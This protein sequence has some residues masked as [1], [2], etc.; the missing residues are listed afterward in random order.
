M[1]Q[2]P[3]EAYRITNAASIDF[4]TSKAS[5]S[6]SESCLNNNIRLLGEYCSEKLRATAVEEWANKSYHPLYSLGTPHTDLPSATIEEFRRIF[7]TV[8]NQRTF[9]RPLK[10]VR[11]QPFRFYSQTNPQQPASN[12]STDGTAKTLIEQTDQSKQH[13]QE[14]SNG[15]NEQKSSNNTHDS[16]STTVAT[17]APPKPKWR[18]YLAWVTLA[19]GVT[20]I[21]SHFYLKAITRKAEDKHAKSIKLDQ[22]LND[23][24]LEELRVYNDFTCGDTLHVQDRLKKEDQESLP[25]EKL[26]TFADFN[27]IVEQVCGKRFKLNYLMVR[28]LEFHER[29]YER[30]EMNSESWLLFMTML[31]RGTA[32]DRLGTSFCVLDRTGLGEISIIELDKLITYAVYM[33]WCY[34]PRMYRQTQKYPPAFTSWPLDELIQD[35]EIK[36]INWKPEPP[37][38]PPKTMMQKFADLLGYQPPE[39]KVEDKK[40]EIEKAEGEAVEND[41]DFSKET[42]E[43]L[44]EEEAEEMALKE[45]QLSF[46]KFSAT[47]CR[48]FP[49]HSTVLRD[50]RNSQVVK[51]ESC[52]GGSP[53]KFQSSSGELKGGS[54][55]LSRQE[56]SGDGSSFSQRSA[57]HNHTFMKSSLVLYLIALTVAC[58]ASFVLQVTYTSSDCTGR[59]SNAATFILNTCFALVNAYGKYVETSGGITFQA[60]SSS[61]CTYP[62]PSLS[63][64][65]TKDNCISDTGVSSLTTVASSLPQ[66][67]GRNDIVL[68]QYADSSCQGQLIG[69]TVLYG[70]GCGNSTSDPSCIA[71]KA[72]SP[73]GSFYTYTSYACGSDAKAQKLPLGGAAQSVT[74]STPTATRAVADCTIQPGSCSFYTRCVETSVPC[75][76]DGYAVAFGSHYC[77]LYL[78]RRQEFTAQGQVWLQSVLVCLQKALLP[79]P[80][81]CPIIQ[82]RAFDS[83]AG[84]YANASSVSVCELSAGDLK[85]IMSI[86]LSPNTIHETIASG[87]QIAR[88]TP[89]FSQFTSTQYRKV[90]NVL[91]ETIDSITLKLSTIMSIAQERIVV[92][93]EDDKKRASSEDYF[94][95]ILADFHGN[96]TVT[97]QAA[98]GALDVAISQQQ[99]GSNVTVVSCAYEQLGDCLVTPAAVPLTIAGYTLSS[100]ATLL[101]AATPLILAALFL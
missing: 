73:R 23:V 88:D 37:P 89:C 11:P 21:T 30:K 82:S 25:E 39:K 33:G 98:S 29:F 86:V 91:G 27:D 15:S 61:D 46:K 55:R 95:A 4:R 20:A 32:Q 60:Y 22:V 100:E 10:P 40:E 99:F 59:P 67:P 31:T 6:G 18:K 24:E 78:Q 16:N 13:G 36:I 70:I 57:S 64:S 65:L 26:Y 9:S 12:A 94:V 43:S 79:L 50:A 42:M 85:T 69:N 48:D 71:P 92:L 35:L 3:S 2:F 90:Q 28:T 97:P 101:I 62:I 76:S 5:S 14:Q 93:G 53:F 56:I 58:Q 96:S 49:L 66:T 54:G 75:G 19:G 44:K 72:N 81:T 84:C 83:H 52:E 1:L 45:G 68:Q 7:Q 34:D 8:S 41:T 80:D 74:Q 17:A 87:Y 63:S 47:F 77:N 38:P 51:S